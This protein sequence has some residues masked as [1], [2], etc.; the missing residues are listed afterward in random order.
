MLKPPTILSINGPIGI[1]ETIYIPA[2]GAARGT[3]V[4]N[5]PNPLHGGTFTNKVI[6]TVA[7]ALSQIGFH[8]Y[9]PNLRGTGNSSGTHD[10]GKGETDDCLAIIDYAQAQHPDVKELIISGFS[11]GG[12]VA[13]LA[14]QH[15]SHNLLLLI[16]AALNHY[17]DH[18]LPAPN[19]ARTI[20]IHGAADEVVAL[21]KPLAW[22]AKQDI[23]VIVMAESSHFFHGKLIP[24]LN[25]ILHFVPPVLEQQKIK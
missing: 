10:Y 8:C 11:F 20:V 22:A 13:N 12:Y 4:I 3:A 6:Q 2:Q 7:K 16:G 23:P 14:A 9:L 18:T 19:V 5:H 24:L 25:N 1:L 15:R 21:H 17:D